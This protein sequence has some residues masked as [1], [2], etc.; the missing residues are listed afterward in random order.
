[1]PGSVYSGGVTKNTIA[2]PGQDDRPARPAPPVIAVHGNGSGNGSSGDWRRS[3][4]KRERPT[5]G[6]PVVAARIHPQLF[7]QIS[8]IVAEERRYRVDVIREALDLWLRLRGHLGGIS[9]HPVGP[10]A[11]P[12][13]A[14]GQDAVA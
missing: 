6:W 2:R 10:P 1:M 7:A 14:S 5:A 13:G 11:P 4:R 9:G 8:R 3:R 12:A